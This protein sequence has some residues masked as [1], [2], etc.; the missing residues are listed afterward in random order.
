MKKAKNNNLLQQFESNKIE[1]LENIKKV[2][3]GARNNTETSSADSG[4]RNPPPEILVP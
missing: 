1:K 3:G 2:V 4:T